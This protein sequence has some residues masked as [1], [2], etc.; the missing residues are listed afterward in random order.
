MGNNL[1]K[2][3]ELTSKDINIKKIDDLRATVG[4][5][6]RRSN[7][8]WKEILSKSSFVYTVWDDDKLIGMGRILEDGIMCMFYDIVVDKNYQGEGIGK[9][10][11]E[12]LL[13]QVKDKEYT[14][15]G[16]FASDENLD[17]LIP[18]YGKFGF[19]L[20]KGGMECKKYMKTGN[21]G[22]NN[23]IETDRNASLK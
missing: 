5:H 20:V 3:K 13:N 7:E 10:I 2:Y 4:W 17:F 1:K 11:M 19:E 9:L 6:K 22:G 12:N 16:L 8:K 14:S 15:I 18:F 21:P 23:I